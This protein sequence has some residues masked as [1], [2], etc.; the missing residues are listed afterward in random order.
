[1]VRLDRVRLHLLLDLLSS[2][3]YGDGSSGNSY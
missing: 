1:M 2:A 3:R